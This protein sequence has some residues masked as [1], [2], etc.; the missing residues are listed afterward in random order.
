MK[1]CP[2][3]A[4]EIQEEA[5]ICRFCSTDLKTGQQRATQ[6]NVATPTSTKPQPYSEGIGCLTFL[7]PGFAQMYTG[8]GGKG[9]AMLLGAI[10]LGLASFGIL[11]IPFMIWSYSDYK[12]SVATK[13]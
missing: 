7:I 2:F 12:K 10:L 9:A 8:H 3:C 11:S 5:T 13:K 6:V 4:E 1:K